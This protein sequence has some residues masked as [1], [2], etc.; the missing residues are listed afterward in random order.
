MRL[1]VGRLWWE[2]KKW[3][4]EVGRGSGEK[5]LQFYLSVLHMCFVC[6]SG[7][8]LLILRTFTY[9]LQ[10][11]IFPRLPEHVHA[12]SWLSRWCTLWKLM[13]CCHVK[14][15]MHDLS[16][17]DAVMNA[18]NSMWHVYHLSNLPKSRKGGSPSTL[19]V[20]PF[21]WS[22]L[23]GIPI[24]TCATNLTA[25]NHGSWWPKSRACN[26]SLPGVF[27]YKACCLDQIVQDASWVATPCSKN[28]FGTAPILWLA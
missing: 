9:K 8:Q 20:I 6:V 1:S 18:T 28:L 27:V 23:E 5:Q 13:W 24:K 21:A 10:G 2:K 17:K 12:F 11:S 7:C 19:Q 26:R 22:N 14:R 25:A 15:C 3:R 16:R 4:W